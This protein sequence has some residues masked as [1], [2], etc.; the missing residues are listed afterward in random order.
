MVHLFSKLSALKPLAGKFSLSQLWRASSSPTSALTRLYLSTVVAVS[1]LTIGGQVITQRALHAQSKD[2][3]VI[4]IAGRQRMLSQKIAKASNA[5]QAARLEDGAS[6]GHQLRLA[7]T[8][9]QEALALFEMS[10]KGLHTGSKAMNLPGDNS[11]TISNMFAQIEADYQAIATAATTLLSPFQQANMVASR[12]IATHEGPFLKQMNDI[13]AQYER[14]A[15]Q[16]V[17]RLKTKQQLLLVLTL[18]V[19]LPVLVPIYQVT[20]RI[21]GMI[22]TI[23]RS[24]IQVTSSSLQISASGKQLEAMVAEQSAASSQ[25]TASSQEIASSVNQLN[26]KVAQVVAEARQAQ[27][28]A[29]VGEQELA[30]MAVLMGQLDQMT[31]E[32]TQRL[33]TISDRASSIDQV[34]LAMTKVADQTNLLS[35]NAAI[36]AEKAG[37]YGT[38]FA[39]LAR[40]IRRLADQSAIATLEIESLVKEMQSA[41]SVGVTEMETFTQQ[42]AEGSDSTVVVTEQVTTI[43]QKVR[44]LLPQLADINVGMDAQSFSAEQIRDAMTQLSLGTDQTVHSLQETNQAL[45]LLQKTAESLQVS[46][47]PAFVKKTSKREGSVEE[48]FVQAGEIEDSSAF[49][50]YADEEGG[51]NL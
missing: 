26:Q 14:E 48:R 35:L 50:G 39:V 9:L 27:E 36:E 45:A 22:S 31:V 43:A 17:A 16:R 28:I 32:I 10:H 12:T 30:S 34:V 51:Y 6:R 20:R 42:V 29:T 7:K 38:G 41:V 15:T 18:L 33:A 40:E 13:V 24:G 49:V 37:E 25:I 47:N 5:L 4:N 2:A 44:A 23:Q 1:L 11:P 8:E 19:L 21:N 46:V 3:A